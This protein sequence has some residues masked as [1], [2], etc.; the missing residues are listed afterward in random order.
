MCGLW[1]FGYRVRFPVRSPGSEPVE[2]GDRLQRT[3]PNRLVESYIVLDRGFF[4]DAGGFGDH[5]QIKVR[6]ETTL[7]APPPTAIYNLHGH[8]SRVNIHSTDSS[9]NSV[10]IG[11]ENVFSGLR[12]AIKSDISA[13]DRD[14]ILGHIDQLESANQSKRFGAEYKDFIAAAA[15]HMTLLAP[16]IPA[17]TSFLTP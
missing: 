4:S 6:K 17:L 2:E 14:V 9:Q 16:F 7:L 8:N 3:L 13:P 5:Y 10:H 11:P 1:W 15:N 12:D